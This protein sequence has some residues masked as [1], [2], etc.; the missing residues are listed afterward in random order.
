MIQEVSPARGTTVYHYDLDGNLVQKVD[1]RSAVANSSYDALNRVT[2]Y[3]SGATTQTYTYDA[4]GNR[5]GYT[6]PSVALT[7]GRRG[8]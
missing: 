4:N 8:L 7:K 6:A 5:T 1:A 2:K 3:T